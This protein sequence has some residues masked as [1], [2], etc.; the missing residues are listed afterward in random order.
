MNFGLSCAA[1]FNNFGGIPTPGSTTH[2]IPSGTAVHGIPSGNAAYSEAPY[3]PVQQLVDTAYICSTMP[4]TDPNVSSICSNT[5]FSQPATVC[6]G[7]PLAS[8]GGG[9]RIFEIEYI[10][11]SGAGRNLGSQRAFHSQGVP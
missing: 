8:A 1:M 2:G 4:P 5:G 6:V 10:N 3:T 11:D 9:N 7:A